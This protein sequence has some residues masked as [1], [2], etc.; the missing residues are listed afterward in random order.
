M[1]KAGEVMDADVTEVFTYDHKG[2]IIGKSVAAK[3]YDGGAV[4]STAYAYAYNPDGSVREETFRPAARA[5][6]SQRYRYNARGVA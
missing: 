5:A 1:Q 3:N 4:H 6:L 2:R